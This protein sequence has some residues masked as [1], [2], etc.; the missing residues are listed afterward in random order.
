MQLKQIARDALLKP[1]QAVSGIVERRHTLPIL[2]N[3]LLEQRNGSLYVTATD[4]EMQITAHS[5]MPGKDGQATTVGARKLQDLLR[6]L[7]EDATLNIDVGN[8]KMTVRAGRSRF[9]LQ[10][11][12]AA[13]YPR[14]G[15][16]AEQLQTLSLPQKDLRAL[17]KLVEFAMAQQ[18]IR[19]YLNGMLLVVD[20][21]TLQAVATDGHRLSWASIGVAGDYARQEVILPRKTVLELGKLLTDSDDPVTLDILANQVRFR[22]ANVELVS[23]VVD[24]K[25]P[26]FNRV[27]PVGHGKQVEL[28]RLELLAALQRAAILS[29]EK[30]R[31]VR[32]VLGADQMKIICTNSEQEEAEEELPIA[33]KGDPLDIGF[34]ITYLVDA[35]S[36]LNVGRVKFAFGDANSSALVTMPERD[37]YK[38]VVMPM[39]I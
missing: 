27:I 4:L 36:N 28:D 16:A 14:I 31:G 34:N 32:V 37:D 10:T 15:L 39:R 18:D 9:N 38:Y 20:K 1:L 6:A 13:D 33:Y 3:V 23:K 21:S 22:F 2:A 19:Y 35:L 25:F 26:D 7:P 29:N 8:N 11:L 12:A 30:F 24:G 5:E 17:F